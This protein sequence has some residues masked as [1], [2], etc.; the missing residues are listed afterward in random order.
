VL[1]AYLA[2]LDATLRGPR[3]AKA[4]LLAE[5]RD[6]LVDATE[7]Y[8]HGGLD[9]AAA[10][11]AAVRDFG[12]LAEIVPAYQA[13]L[14]WVQGR[15][16]ALT[17]LAV[18]AAQPLLWNRAFH[19]LTGTPTDQSLVADE[20]VENLG[21]VTILLALLTVLAY[22]SPT[23]RTRLTRFTG[24]A[25]LGMCAMFVSFSALLT[26]LT[27]QSNPIDLMWTATFALAPMTCVA[28]SARRC[29]ATA[30]AEAATPR[31]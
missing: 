9:R 28:M 2:E 20:V 12:E 10:E 15:R 29:L 8:E 14:G 18:S 27:G 30:A 5:A 24:I 7:A 3:R 21:A 22:R 11:H 23:V 16:T 31:R 17:V 13:E 1:D 19:W 26:I 4:D 25:A 6:H